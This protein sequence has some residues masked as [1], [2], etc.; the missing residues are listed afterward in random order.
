MIWQE[1]LAGLAESLDRLEAYEGLSREDFLASEE[2][3]RAIE[4]Y[5]QITIERCLDLGRMIIR[6]EHW[7]EPA[8]NRGVFE[9]LAD[10]GILPR[11]DLPDL[12][13]MAGMRNI[14]V[15]EY[16]RLDPEAV[17]AVLQRHL[18]DVRRFALAVGA[19]WDKAHPAGV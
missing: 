5:L 12:L 2:R 15:H 6:E 8:T 9:T 19:H 11:N 16:D 10:K 3:Q 13:N 7:A 18:G 14:L 1:R 17:H 4:R